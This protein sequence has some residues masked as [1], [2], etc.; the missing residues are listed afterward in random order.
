V[1]EITRVL[2]CGGR[3]YTDKDILWDYLD[4]CMSEWCFLVLIHGDARGA[5]RLSDAWAVEHGIQPAAC[6]ANWR[7]YPRAAGPIR[8][9]RMLILQPQKCIAF[10]GGTGTADM[11]RQCES[12]DIEVRR[13]PARRDYVFKI[14]PRTLNLL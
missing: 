7:R 4:A 8:N 1:E 12:R 2:V 14:P 13:V 3:D 11:I 9:N 6:R 5:D 10:P